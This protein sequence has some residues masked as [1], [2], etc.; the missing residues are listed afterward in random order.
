[1]G[2]VE[3]LVFVAK[4][5]V[6]EQQRLGYDRVSLKTLS[7]RS[8]NDGKLF[9]RIAAERSIAVNTLETCVGYLAMGRHWAAGSVPADVLQH[10]I[11]LGADVGPQSVFPID[12]SSSRRGG[13]DAKSLQSVEA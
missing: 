4:R 12:V 10:L 1:M 13:D 3:R 7:S 2:L 11:V 8:T 9:A 5:W 6:E